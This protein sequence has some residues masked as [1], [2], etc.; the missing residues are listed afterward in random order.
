MIEEIL[1]EI[2]REY[3]ELPQELF[4]LAK[5]VYSNDNDENGHHQ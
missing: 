2:G 1:N 5:N 3:S 4:E